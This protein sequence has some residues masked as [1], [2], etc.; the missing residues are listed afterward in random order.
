MKEKELGKIL[1]SKRLKEGFSAEE[2]SRRCGVSAMHIGRIE[3]GEM[4]PTVGILNKIASGL[5]ADMD[6]RFTK[7]GKRK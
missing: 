3:R 2:L 4:S 5:E 7:K 6:L 1:K